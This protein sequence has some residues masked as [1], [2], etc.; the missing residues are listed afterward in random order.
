VTDQ[1]DTPPELAST[2]PP[3]GAT[4]VTEH[5]TSDPTGAPRIMRPTLCR[6]VWYADRQVGG[7][8]RAAKVV[9]T[10]DSISHDEGV[11][12]PTDELHVH[13]LVMPPQ[14]AAYNA[15]DVAYDANGAPGTWRWPTRVDA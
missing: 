3:T 8:V 15:L 4:G 13:L 2:T 5:A 12:L 11:P 14:G 7:S 9:G 10:R 6:D 1:Q